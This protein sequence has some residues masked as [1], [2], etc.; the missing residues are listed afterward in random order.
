LK[1]VRKFPQRG[2]FGERRIYESPGLRLGQI[3]VEL[4]DGGR[5][6]PHVIRL[7][8]SAMLAL[9]DDHDQTLLVRRHR[10]VPDRESGG[11]QEADPGV[12]TA[13]L[14]SRMSPQATAIDVGCC[15]GV[16]PGCRGKDARSSGRC[17]RGGSGG[18]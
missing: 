5:R 7:H 11:G 12:D 1:T 16:S 8:R 3:D 2:R 6:W 15:G 14:A 18:R 10:V 13:V 9:V 17:T 4:P